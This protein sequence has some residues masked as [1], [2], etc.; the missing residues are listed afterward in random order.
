MLSALPH[1]I[2]FTYNHVKW[3]LLLLSFTDG[4]TEVKEMKSLLNHAAN[5][6]YSWDLDLD[7]SDTREAN[8]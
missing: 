2:P 1:I 8:S 5:K 6:W 4:G 3:A 7:P